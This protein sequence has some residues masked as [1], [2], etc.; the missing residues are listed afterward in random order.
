MVDTVER[1]KVES[2]KAARFLSAAVVG[3]VAATLVVSPPGSSAQEGCE[4]PYKPLWVEYV[5]AGSLSQWGIDPW[6]PHPYEKP[7]S[8][9]TL[10]QPGGPQSISGLPSH[11]VGGGVLRVEREGGDETFEARVLSAGSAGLVEFEG[12]RYLLLQS[13][14]SST[15]S[16][17][18]LFSFWDFDDPCRQLP[19]ESDDAA[20]T[21]PGHE[22]PA[23]SAP[24]ADPI[25]AAVGYTG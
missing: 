12:R 4:Q 21:A 15:G 7:F 25:S 6:P 1:S 24:A 3:L 14:V 17:R 8:A 13:S 11:T 9:V 5:G 10:D 18:A 2:T 22:D 23:G 16:F 20:T 19:V